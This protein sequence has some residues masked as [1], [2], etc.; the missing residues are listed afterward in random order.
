MKYILIITAIC[1][2]FQTN[3]SIAQKYCITENNSESIKWYEE[4]EAYDALGVWV[5]FGGSE[6][7]YYFPPAEIPV[8]VYGYN[9]KNEEDLFLGKVNNDGC[10]E[11]NVKPTKI[12][13]IIKWMLVPPEAPQSNCGS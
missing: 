11:F 10:W 5:C 1:L 6:Y 3:Q 8:V 12:N 7:D 2:F 9:T 13:G 4:R